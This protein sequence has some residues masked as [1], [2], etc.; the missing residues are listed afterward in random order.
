MNVPWQRAI[1]RNGA[2]WKNDDKLGVF[3]LVPPTARQI[4]NW[5]PVVY[6]PGNNPIFSI[7]EELWRAVERW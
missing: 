6:F 1:T 2:L 4:E 3:G 5:Q 7:F